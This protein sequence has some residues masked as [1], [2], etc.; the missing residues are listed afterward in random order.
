MLRAALPVTSRRSDAAPPATR[1][2]SSAARG[3]AAGAPRPSPPA[4][5]SPRART[6]A[7]APARFAASPLQLRSA[8]ASRVAAACAS[9]VCAR[10]RAAGVALGARGV[11]PPPRRRLVCASSASASLAVRRLLPGARRIARAWRPPNPA[12]P[13]A[14]RRA[15]RT[16]SRRLDVVRARCAA[17]HLDVPLGVRELELRGDGV[18]ALGD[19]LLVRVRHLLDRHRRACVRA[20]F[21]RGRSEERGGQ[22]DA[23]GMWSGSGGVDDV[24]EE[25]ETRRRRVRE[26]RRGDDAEPRDEI[27]TVLSSPSIFALRAERVDHDAELAQQPIS[28]WLNCPMLRDSSSFAS[29]CLEKPWSSSSSPDTPAPPAR[30]PAESL[31]RG[32]TSRSVARVRSAR[33]PL[34]PAHPPRRW[35]SNFRRATITSKTSALSGFAFGTDDTM[36]RIKRRSIDHRAREGS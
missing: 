34:R 29:R 25:G 10:P 15:L 8:R 22:H 36:Y 7:S 21:V 16:R 19:V 23:R 30:A 35:N 20:S 26:P 2:A 14:A 31:P 33:A 32:T 17:W 9:V 6:S 27:R 13:R 24:G 3:A 11:P 12:P 1:L 4:P 18:V 28:A 5:P